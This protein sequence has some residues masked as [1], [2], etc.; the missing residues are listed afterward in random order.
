ML[1]CAGE[2]SLSKKANV[3]NLP[4]LKSC[5]FEKYFFAFLANESIFFFFQVKSW[6]NP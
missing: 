3:K 6:V 1:V 4:N 2:R 5:V